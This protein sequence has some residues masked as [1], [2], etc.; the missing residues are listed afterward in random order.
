M[1][2]LTILTSPGAEAII[3]IL[4]QSL[5]TEDS[6]TSSSPGDGDL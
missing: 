2:V 5:A 4:A 3:G 6:E 1:L